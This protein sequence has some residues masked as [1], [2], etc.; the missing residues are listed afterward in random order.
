MVFHQ[1]VVSSYDVGSGQIIAYGGGA[2]Q[3]NS[4]SEHG[5][6]DEGEEEERDYSDQE[7]DSRPQRA[8]PRMPISPRRPADDD[9]SDEA[10]DED[11]SAAHPR[12]HGTKSSTGKPRY[13]EDTEDDN[14][15]DLFGEGGGR[16]SEGDSMFG[17]ESTGQRSSSSKTKA[18]VNIK[19]VLSAQLATK[20]GAPPA[21]AGASKSKGGSAAKS[22]SCE[23]DPDDEEDDD[24][25]GGTQEDPYS[26]FGAAPVTK[27][28]TQVSGPCQSTLLTLCPWSSVWA[29]CVLD[30][31]SV[32]LFSLSNNLHCSGQAI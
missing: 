7:V 11:T 12:Q 2:N 10:S 32:L 29:A 5:H 3:K 14:S 9:Y 16:G 4:N 24:M 20:I 13:S 28:K 23:E 17:R 27:R 25:F 1:V 6:Y 18:P 26:L 8:I 31:S 30:H 19:D 22:A 21:A 15:E